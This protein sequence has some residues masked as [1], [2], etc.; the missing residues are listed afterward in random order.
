MTV[1]VFIKALL[2]W[3]IILVFAV[4]NGA[5]RE[6]MLIQLL[7]YFPGLII[8]GIILSCFIFLAA[9]FSASWYG[10]LTSSHY[11]IIGLFWLFLTLLF[12]FV[13][14]HFIEHKDWADLLQ[15][16]T[17]KGGNIW[18]VV[19]VVTLISPWV[20]ARIRGLV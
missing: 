2:L 13:F 20:T 10:R 5:L 4:I 8:S 19:L 6:K 9:F 11:W 12:E 17:F 18:P 15:A 7:G 1:T 16:Y 14:G 3:I